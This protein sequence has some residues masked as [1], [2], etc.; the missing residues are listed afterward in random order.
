VFLQMAEEEGRDDSEAA[1]ETQAALGRVAGGARSPRTASDARWRVRSPRRDCVDSP[2]RRR[3]GSAGLGG[4]AGCGFICAGPS[5]AASR[6]SSRICNR[7]TAL[8]IK[9]ATVTVEASSR[10]AIC[11]PKPVSIGWSESRHTT[12]TR[13]AIRRSRRCSFFPA[14]DD[15]I[16]ININP[17]D[18]RIDTFQRVGRGRAARQQDRLGG[19]LHAS[20]DQY[21][22]D[23]SERA[24]AA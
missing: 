2:W 20:S 5:G 24:L 15:T 3:D 19:A 1:R 8:E 10:T 12:P 21:R 23:L 13:G 18:L 17:A 7:A 14:V 16:E 4:D 22:R 6:P 9:S 11:A